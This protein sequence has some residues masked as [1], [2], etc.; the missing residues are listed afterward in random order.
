MTDT[1]LI[2]RLTRLESQLSCMQ[3]TQE[4]IDG[5]V[6]ELIELANHGRGAIWT[7]I[8]IGSAITFVVANA[9]SI[10]QFVSD[11]LKG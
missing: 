9:K 7:F 4:D 11:S 8:G 6:R 2:E 1:E 5:E 3:K 10:L